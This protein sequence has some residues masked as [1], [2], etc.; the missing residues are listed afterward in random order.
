MTHTEGWLREGTCI[1]VLQETVWAGLPTKETRWE[2]EFQGV[3]PREEL[4]ARAR[5]AQAA[6]ELL[7]ALKMMVDHYVQLASSGDCGFWNPEDEEQVIGAREAI[8]KAEG[9][10]Q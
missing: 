2:A 6:P 3:A 4:E 8:A 9:R 1:Y 5:L 10:D 7:A